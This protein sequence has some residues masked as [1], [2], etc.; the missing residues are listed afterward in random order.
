M[1]CSDVCWHSAVPHAGRYLLA[2]SVPGDDDRAR[3]VALST[4]RD[5]AVDLGVA[6][7]REL[8][9]PLYLSIPPD[10]EPS[11]AARAVAA[12]RFLHHP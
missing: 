3:D 7:C 6:L 10:A 1:T 5:H 12:A 2:F 8:G 4:C 11:A 9:V